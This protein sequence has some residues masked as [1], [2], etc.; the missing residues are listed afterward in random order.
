MAGE[1][2]APIIAHETGMFITNMA[3]VG[4]TARELE[5]RLDRHII[6]PKNSIVCILIGINDV[7][8]GARFEDIFDDIWV[9]I[10]KLKFNKNIVYVV[11]PLPCDGYKLMNIKKATTKRQLES[12]IISRALVSKAIRMGTS[13]L[14]FD[15]VSA[16]SG[17]STL[18]KE[19]DAG[20]GLHLN[21]F[22][23]DILAMAIVNKITENRLM[24]IYIGINMSCERK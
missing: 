19:Y 18:P 5:D 21:E 11:L 7:I 17:C 2:V 23:Q 12:A 3:I 13:D 6:E 10:C 14:S 1:Y 4:L 22:G 20:D 9:S 8:D 15:A 24:R 16:M